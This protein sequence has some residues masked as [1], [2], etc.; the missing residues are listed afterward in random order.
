[1]VMGGDSCSEA[2]GFESQGSILDGHFFTLICCKNCIVC[3]KRRKINEKEAG[4]GPF[5]KLL[6]PSLNKNLGFLKFQRNCK[7][8]LQISS[9]LEKLNF[10]FFNSEA[11]LR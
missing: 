2:R 4:V 1:M 7:K 9:L 5:K 11:R 10:N 8:Y 3:L 6:Y